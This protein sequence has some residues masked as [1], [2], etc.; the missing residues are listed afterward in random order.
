[1]LTKIKMFT[2]KVRDEFYNCMYQYW[3]SE[4]EGF[5]QLGRYDEAEHC[6]ALAAKYLVKEYE[7]LAKTIKLA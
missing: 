3:T 4:A 7:L 5:I 6:R 1:M 2:I